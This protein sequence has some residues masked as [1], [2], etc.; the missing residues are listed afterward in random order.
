MGLQSG[1]FSICISHAWPPPSVSAKQGWLRKAFSVDLRHSLPG[2][3]PALITMRSHRELSFASNPRWVVAFC[4]IKIRNQRM[5]R[6]TIHGGRE[7]GKAAVSILVA[8]EN[9]QP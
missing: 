8:Q 9:N 6:L 3:E 2:Q 1:T 4:M 5:R 7:L